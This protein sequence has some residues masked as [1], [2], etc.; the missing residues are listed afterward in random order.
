MRTNRWLARAAAILLLAAGAVFAPAGPA[1]AAGTL[2]RFWTWN[3]AG[4]KEGLA[5][6]S[7]TN[8]MITAAANS[9]AYRA[10]FAVVNEICQS[11]YNALIAEL[12]ELGFPEDPSNFARFTPATPK[13]PCAAGEAKGAFGNAIF[14]RYRLDDAQRWT[15]TGDTT[16]E[17]H[18][19]TCVNPEGKPQLRFC[20]THITSKGTRDANNVFYSRHQLEDVYDRLEAFNTAGHTAVLAG[21]LNAQPQYERLDFFGGYHEMDNADDANCRGYGEW[22]ATQPNIANPTPCG[23]SLTKVDHIFA[24][25][26]RITGAYTADVLGLALTCTGVPA[27]ADYKAGA[28]SDHRILVGHAYL[29]V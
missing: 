25:K 22:T 2:Y 17:I 7:T 27:T 15:L 11:Q 9:I 29:G 19:L 4:A 23:A 26:N 5:Y 28:C 6:G 14:S 20:G 1:S 16:G 21:D 12:R 3:V 13:G 8:G 10:D 24:R 18:T